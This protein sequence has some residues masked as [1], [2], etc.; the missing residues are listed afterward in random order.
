MNSN[1]YAQNDS[2]NYQHQM[3]ANQSAAVGL[4]DVPPRQVL[5]QACQEHAKTLQ[6]RI[7]EYE[8]GRGQ[9]EANKAELEAIMAAVSAL[10]GNGVSKAAL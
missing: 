9:Y 10:A 7:A 4:R 3:Q 6:K 8:A 5:M 2:V 1:G